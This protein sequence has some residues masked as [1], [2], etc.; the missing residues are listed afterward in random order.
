MISRRRLGL[1]WIEC[2]FALMLQLVP[3]SV[4]MV[5]HVPPMYGTPSID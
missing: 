4:V 1:S 5:V 2:E 3:G